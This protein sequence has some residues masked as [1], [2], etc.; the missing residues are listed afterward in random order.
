MS[1]HRIE[2][3]VKPKADKQKKRKSPPRPLVRTGGSPDVLSRRE[4][5]YINFYDMAQ[6]S[7]G[8]G[9]D[10][11]FYSANNAPQNA[12]GDTQSAAAMS[13][14][15]FNG[16]DIPLLAIPTNQWNSKFRK[17]TK[18]TLSTK[19][20]IRAAFGASNDVLDALPEWTATGLKLSQSDLNAGVRIGGSD[21]ANIG[22]NDVSNKFFYSI[23]LLDGQSNI[24]ITASA[25]YASSSVAFTPSQ[26]MDVFFPPRFVF[27]RGSVINS[28][29][30]DKWHYGDIN[31]TFPRRFGINTTDIFEDG[32]PA[33]PSP[34]AASLSLSSGFLSALTNWRDFVSGREYHYTYPTA[35]ASEP[36]SFP[37][38]ANPSIKGNIGVS[39]LPIEFPDP[40]LPN[41]A[42]LAVVKK[43]NLFYY[44][45]TDGF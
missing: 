7:N 45:W 40:N 11:A 9:F 24:K 32:G 39:L 12:G 22:D 17:V 38:V 27:M 43:G 33:D 18:G 15:D 42:L 23:T 14:L 25:N 37:P 19:Y 2:I 3:T 21:L 36:A 34:P 35:W 8:S 26:R 28:T 44:F 5:G 29:F 20:A 1:K 10:E 6:I 4:G 16:R 41:G 30:G 31:V 13:V